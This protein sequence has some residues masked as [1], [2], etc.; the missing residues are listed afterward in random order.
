MA[1]KISILEGGVALDLTTMTSQGTL[2]VIA[3]SIHRLN[4]SSRCRNSGM[5][6]L[7]AGPVETLAS[8]CGREI[9][10]GRRLPI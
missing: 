8:C 4:H 7:A 5:M 9:E 6:M 2:C 10:T 1:A 3:D